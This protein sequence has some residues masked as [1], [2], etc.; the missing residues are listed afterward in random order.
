VETH[1]KKDTIKQRTQKKDLTRTIKNRPEYTKI[2]EEISKLQ[3]RHPKPCKSE[4]TK[5]EKKNR[6]QQ[7]EQ[8]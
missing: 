3:I 4:K 5:Q 6:D 1:K 2:G 8:K 7:T